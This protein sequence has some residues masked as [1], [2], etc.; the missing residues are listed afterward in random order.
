MKKKILIPVD[1][2]NEMIARKLIHHV[3]AELKNDNAEFHFL[4][5]VTTYSCY[6]I[7][8]GGWYE[9]PKHYKLEKAKSRL[10]DITEIFHLPEDKKSYHITEGNPRD[11]ILAYSKSLPADLIIIPSSFPDL[12]TYFFGSTALSIVRHAKCVVLVVR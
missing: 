9:Q 8:A 7:L 12:S 10:K 4:T 3:A 1:I 5:V 2:E 6:D 11:E